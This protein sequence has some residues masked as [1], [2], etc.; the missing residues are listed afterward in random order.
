M[1]ER[2]C[3]AD[4]KP[5][6]CMNGTVSEDVRSRQAE[7]EKRLVP[8]RIN[9]QTTIL[10]PKEK[11]NEAYRQEWIRL[12]KQRDEELLRMK[13]YSV[14]DK[15][16]LYDCVVERGMLYKDAAKELGVCSVTVSDMLNYG[17]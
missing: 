13:K 14:I 7:K 5:D 15:D 6:T 12:H 9:A 2:K 16:K 3:E 17:V 1:T 4:K 8:L 10:V 11:Q